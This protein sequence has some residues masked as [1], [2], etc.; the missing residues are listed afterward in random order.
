MPHLRATFASLE[1]GRFSKTGHMRTQAIETSYD[2]TIDI[3]M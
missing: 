1:I 3:E 2:L